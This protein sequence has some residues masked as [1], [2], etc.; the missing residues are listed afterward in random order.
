MVD[1]I[2]IYS[3][4]TVAIYFVVRQIIKFF[5]GDSDCGACCGC[6]AKEECPSDE[7]EKK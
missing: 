2:I 4:I 6:S 5:R 3:I 7:S 1:K